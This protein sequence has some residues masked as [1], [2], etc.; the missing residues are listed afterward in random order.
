MIVARLSCALVLAGAAVGC[1]VVNE[2][3]S[4]ED[5]ARN[6][7]F[8]SFQ[9]APKHLDSVASYSNDETPWT[10]SIY[11]PPLRYHYLKRP[12]ELVPRTLVE[13]PSTVYLDK[14]GNAL[15]ANAPASDI[16]ESLV[17]LRIKP[18]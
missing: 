16:A 6:L 5:L 13:M 15:P 10:Y 17:E 4:K 11:E 2:P 18:G 1:G 8:S 14:S 3:V 7:L 12:Y 9:A